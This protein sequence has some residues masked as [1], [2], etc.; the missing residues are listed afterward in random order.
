MK[1]FAYIALIAF[2]CLQLSSAQDFSS[3]FDAEKLRSRVIRLSADDFEGRG[4][5]TA[6]GKRAAQY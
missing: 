2:V 3:R 4:T 5:G 6:G 1:R